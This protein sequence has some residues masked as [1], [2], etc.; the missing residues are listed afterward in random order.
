MDHAYAFLLDFFPLVDEIGGENAVLCSTMQMI[1]L[2]VLLERTDDGSGRL[3][4]LL[5]LAADLGYVS[6]EVVHFLVNGLKKLN[7][8]P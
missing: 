5:R 2:D 4:I 6:P 7:S 3:D 8:D 1:A